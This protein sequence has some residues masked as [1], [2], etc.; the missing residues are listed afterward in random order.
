MYY[1]ASATD[2]E[3]S[4]KSGFNEPKKAYA[5][6]L[7][8]R[9][10]WLPIAARIKNKVLMFAYKTTTG[11]APIYLNSQVQTF[12]PSRSLLSASER[13][14]V[15]KSQRGTKSLSGT[16]SWTVTSWWN[17][18][19]ISIRT[20]ESLDSSKGTSFSAAPDQLI[21]AL[22]YSILLYSILFYSILFYYMCT[23]LD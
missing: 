20:A 13:R 21:L 5:T 11:A 18:L 19:P 6:P 2:P 1:Q 3:C 8:I 10:H 15:V 16:F 7:F 4:S 14:L 17:N 23:V 9:L 12:A 22:T